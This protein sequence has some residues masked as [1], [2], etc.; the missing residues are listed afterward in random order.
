MTAPTLHLHTATIHSRVEAPKRLHQRT[1]TIGSSYVR[2]RLEVAFAAARF[3]EGIVG[4]LVSFWM[5]YWSTEVTLA[6][7]R[8][9]MLASLS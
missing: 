3:N 7:A 4:G 9:P 6:P 5:S 8:A 2:R 1:A